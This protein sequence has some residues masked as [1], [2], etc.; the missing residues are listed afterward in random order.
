MGPKTRRRV[1]I[2]FL[3]FFIIGILMGVSE[4]LIAIHFATDA[5]I[6]PYVFKVALLVALPFAVISELLVDSKIFR[7]LFFGPD[8]SHKSSKRK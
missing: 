8:N 6:T 2:R 4:D 3:E 5:A 1:L 7:R